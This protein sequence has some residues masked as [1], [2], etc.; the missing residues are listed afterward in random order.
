VPRIKREPA[1]FWLLLIGVAML[2]ACS[3]GD[4]P[5]WAAGFAAAEQQFQI[6]HHAQAQEGDGTSADARTTFEDM[7]TLWGRV[8]RAQSG[9]MRGL[10]HMHGGGA[11]GRHAGAGMIDPAT[12]MRFNEMNQQML[13]YSLG[14]QQMMNQSGRHQMAAMYGQ[15]AE[16][17]RTLLS[18][19]PASPGAEG[20][21]EGTPE[22]DGAAAF[23]AN[24]ASCHGARGE[25][26]AGVFPPVNGSVMVAGEA[27]TIVKIV[28]QGL[29]GPVSVAG[30]AYNGFMP[31]FGATLSDAQIAAVLT[32]L[33]S[34]PGNG[35]GAVTIDDVRGIRN[36]TADRSQP[37][38]S[39]ELGLP[40]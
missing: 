22:S 23:A 12:M 31:A 7:Q 6:I 32:H 40:H 2:S 20:P 37:W 26:V 36:K 11:M 8:G 15:M 4:V 3:R 17:M 10:G 28:L 39:T 24:C 38:T 14:M 18:R 16:R 35:A 34:L 19:M 1:M 21:S 25:G 33:R 13:S 27:E 29:Q 5:P 30:A 9:M